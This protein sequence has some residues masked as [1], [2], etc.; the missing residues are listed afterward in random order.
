MA[1]AADKAYLIDLASVFFGLANLC[2]AHSVVTDDTPEHCLPSKDILRVVI[3]QVHFSWP[4]YWNSY[5]L[6]II[7]FQKIRYCQLRQLSEL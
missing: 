6:S 2:L 3:S 5:S 4:T 7:R 1:V